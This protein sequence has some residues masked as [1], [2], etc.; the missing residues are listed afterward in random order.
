M[1][2]IGKVKERVEKTKTTKAEDAKAAVQEYLGSLRTICSK[3]N[4]VHF[5]HI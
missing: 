3:K 5:E 4:L 2:L 1:N